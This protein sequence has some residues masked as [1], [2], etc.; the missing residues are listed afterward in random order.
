VLP[1]RSC[2]L[3]IC[4]YRKRKVGPATVFGMSH[5]CTHLLDISSNQR[6]LGSAPTSADTPAPLVFNSCDSSYT[7]SIAYTYQSVRALLRNLDSTQL[8]S[9]STC[10]F[11][12]TNIIITSFSRIDAL[13]SSAEL[14]FHV[15]FLG[16]FICT[17]P[18]PGARAIIIY[19]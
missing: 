1:Y 9:A 13:V 8:T 2:I 11:K 18:S 10:T 15:S 3:P 14:R 6:R 7:I 16:G 19:E 5:W 12:L 17:S 4:V